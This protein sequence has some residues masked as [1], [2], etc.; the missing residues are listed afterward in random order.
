MVQGM[1]D[2]PLLP[3]GFN[4]VPHACD[5]VDGRGRSEPQWPV[6]IDSHQ[7][8]DVLIISEDMMS[9]FATGCPDYVVP[10]E[11][12]RIVFGPEVRRQQIRKSA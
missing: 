4:S 1:T 9:I 7:A 11:N 6:W 2:H 3:C 8:L 5:E 10:P 12:N